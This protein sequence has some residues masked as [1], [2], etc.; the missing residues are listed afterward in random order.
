MATSAA[1]PTISAAPPAP[2]PAPTTPRT[3]SDLHH[4]DLRNVTLAYDLLGRLFQVSRDGVTT[5]FVHDG[6]ELVAEYDGAGTP[7]RRYAHGTGVDDPVLWFEGGASFDTR[8]SLF[9]DHQGSIVAAA[10]ATGNKLHIN[11]YDPWGVPGARSPPA[12]PIPGRCGSPSWACT[13]TRR[14]STR[15]RWGGSCRPIRSGM[16][17]A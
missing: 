3:A 1:A 14:G 9:A 13:T 17:V 10:D 4:D 7:L 8:R 16:K 5:R 12:S 2:P 6:D 15:R 11:A